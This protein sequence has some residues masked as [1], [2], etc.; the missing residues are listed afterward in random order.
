MLPNR[1][2]LNGWRGIRCAIQSMVF[3]MVFTV[4]IK[5]QP[6]NTQRLQEIEAN[7]LPTALVDGPWQHERLEDYYLDANLELAYRFEQARRVFESGK[8]RPFSMVTLI[9]GDAGVGKTFLKSRVFSE[10]YSKEQVC[11]F[12]V[13]D[14][15]RTWED[16]GKV[17]S[18]PD[19]CCRDTVVCSL[20]SLRDVTWPGLYDY[21]SRKAAS[22]YVIDSLDEVHPDDYV[23]L[24]EQVDRFAFGSER[25]FVHVVVLGRGIAFRDYWK[26]T[27]GH[28]ATSRLNLYI[29]EP[30]KFNTTGD[31]LLSTW[32]YHRYAHALRW[33]SDASSDVSLHDF[34]QWAE[35]GF[36]RAGRFQ[37]L[38]CTPADAVD[39]RSEAELKRLMTTH[40]YPQLAF[41]NLAGN[42]IL[43][44]IV[45]AK[46]HR[47]VRCDKQSIMNEYFE[48]W[49]VRDTK[50]SNRPS[51]A[52]P[53]H[54]ELYVRLLEELSAKVLR[55]DRLDSHGFFW[56][57]DHETIDCTHGGQQLSFPAHQILDRSGLT[58]L[59]PRTPGARRYRFEP[60]WLHR[61]LVDSYNQRTA[62]M[63]IAMPTARGTSMTADKNVNV[64]S[65]RSARRK[66]FVA[67]D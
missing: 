19:L 40:R 7:V 44:E 46:V 45:S 17:K 58:H 26:K 6:L 21:L 47:G 13:K 34:Q 16:Q 48:K 30:P 37:E 15:Y 11:R 23:P 29:L 9:S 4:P 5:A 62:A 36:A 50:S 64:H 59:D 55:E 51:D 65:P 54:K 31:L 24:L 12:D 63:N 27:A 41:Q 3:I 66:D 33:H 20:P 53:Q 14:L 22:F 10:A 32:N 1:F 35:S 43:R 2:E 56:V 25:Q 57:S 67:T 28:F 38:D 8:P 18:K 61:M 49:L 42:S 60:V 39:A 52:N